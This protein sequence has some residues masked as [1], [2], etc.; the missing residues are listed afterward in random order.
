MGALMMYVAVVFNRAGLRFVATHDSARSAVY[1]V[2]RSVRGS[3]RHGF[4]G[5]GY[6]LVVPVGSVS[7]SGFVVRG[8]IYSFN[9]E[10]L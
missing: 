4:G 9:S 1:Y 7:V 10:V 6:V 3:V 2:R 5:R 8:L